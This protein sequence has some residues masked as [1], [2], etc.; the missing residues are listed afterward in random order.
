MQYVLCLISLALYIGTPDDVYS[1]PI[2]IIAFIIFIMNA[3]LAIYRL[4]SIEFFGFN[5]LFTLSFFGCCYIFPI[6]IYNIDAAYSLFEF[7]Y[8][9]KVVTKS[10]CMATLAY[11]CYTC[12]LL[13]R[14]NIV[15][16]YK[17]NSIYERVRIIMP[18]V[19]SN[20][21]FIL[22]LL[23]LILFIVSGGYSYLNSQYSEGTMGG[24]IV[25]YF[26][27]LVSTLPVLLS[28]VVNCNFS[29]KNILI[30]IVVILIFLSVGSRTLPLALILGVFYVYSLQHKVPNN[31]VIIFLITGLFFMS[32][33]GVHRGGEEM[34]VNSDVGFWNTFLDLIINNRNLYEAYSIVD[35]SG[36]VPTVLLGPILAAI[37][38]SQSFFVN[39]TGLPDYK[40]NSASYFTIDRLGDNPSFGL[41]TNIVGDVFLGGGIIAVIVLFYLL[42]SIVTKSLYKIHVEKNYMWY[43]FYVSLVTSGIYICRGP[44]FWFVRPFA[45]TIIIFFIVRYIV[46]S[47]KQHTSMRR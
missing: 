45:W 40:M 12:G 33:I 14:I 6:F 15:A 7:G 16:E 1:L 38:M 19:P 10:T 2:C 44:F 24:G 31:V 17:K 18:D 23:F 8:D 3:I 35:R 9:P 46:H 25:L 39:L 42:G 47:L 27:A 36:V 11:S 34:E 41:G 4:K 37:P 5:L 22:S 13:R 43:I 28:Y 26:Y 20:A 29:V 21:I 30:S 32:Y